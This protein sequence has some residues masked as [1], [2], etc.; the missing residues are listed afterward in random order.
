MYSDFGEVY[1]TRSFTNSEEY[2]NFDLDDYP[3]GYYRSGEQ[4]DGLQ[5]HTIT[6]FSKSL[7][8]PKAYDITVGDDLI[9]AVDET[10]SYVSLTASDE[11]EPE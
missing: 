9:L 2:G 5:Y 1:S 6:N 7:S 4:P 8:V 10:G 3:V 11:S